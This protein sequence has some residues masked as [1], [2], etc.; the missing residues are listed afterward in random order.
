MLY[1]LLSSLSMRIMTAN[2]F[3][4]NVS[5]YAFAE[6]LD[7]HLPDLVAIQELAQ[8]SAVVLADRYDHGMAFPDGVQGCALVGNRPIA[9]TRTE[10][11]FRPLLTAPVEVGDRTVI[12][13]AVHL[14]NPVGLKDVAFRRHQVRALLDELAGT[15]PMV[16]V[17]DLNSSPAWPAYRMVTQ[18][19][20]DGV[21]DWARR[22]GTRPTRTWNWGTGSLKLLRIDHIMVRG[23][24]L[25][26][27][28]VIDVAGSDHRAIV[29][30][31]V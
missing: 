1:R 28:K 4:A 8:P 29:A 22:S 27:V 30:D 10:L 18:H 23:V 25:A 6:V 24:E 16:L 5:A 14:A 19:L 17:G 20:R 13:G 26:D 21:K 2:L 9:V 12:I 15:E 7:A 3:N 11:P 31:L